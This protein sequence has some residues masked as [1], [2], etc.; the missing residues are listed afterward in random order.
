M[1]WGHAVVAIIFLGIGFFIG[2]NT[3]SSRDKERVK[4][5]LREHKGY[6]EDPRRRH[7][8]VPK[9]ENG[10]YVRKWIEI[11]NCLGKGS[12]EYITGDL[13]CQLVVQPAGALG[14]GEKPYAQFIERVIGDNRYQQY[15]AVY[16]S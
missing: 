3:E 16:I 11:A 4:C 2:R 9:V 5:L 13:D 6:F 10:A 8:I 7:Y 15:W 1:D 12:G 14:A